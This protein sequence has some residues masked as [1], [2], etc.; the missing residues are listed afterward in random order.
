MLRPRAHP[1]HMTV[2]QA[3][4]TAERIGAESTWFIHMSHEIRHADVAPVLPARMNLA[5]DGVR[6]R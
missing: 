2:D 4:E 5:W 3:V 6:V 1:T